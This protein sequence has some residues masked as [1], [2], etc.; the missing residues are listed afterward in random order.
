MEVART[1]GADLIV[2]GTEG[3][4]LFHVGFSGSVSSDVIRLSRIP[5]L[6]A[7]HSRTATAEVGADVCSRALSSLLLPTDFSPL[8]ERA[9][10]LAC[11]LAPA[12][13]GRLTLV[14]AIEASFAA[15]RGGREQAVRED[16]E[17][18]AERAR[19]LGI[20]DVRTEVLL[21][22][23]DRVVAE[24]IASG[25]YSMVILAPRCLDTIDQEFGSVTNAVIRD[26]P[27]P[28][29]LA[30]PACDQPV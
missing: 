7:P 2:M 14:H 1:H 26:C 30:P 20:A 5:V 4:G 10:S 24:T 23:P 28:M 6:L 13:V 9:F 11:L 21:G 18:L 29:L 12:G 16:L 22:N 17:A 3:R 15:L 27:I 25:H 19:T 8:A